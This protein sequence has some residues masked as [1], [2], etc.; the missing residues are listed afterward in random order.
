MLSAKLRVLLL[1]TTGL[2]T[3]LAAEAAS[4]QQ[5]G[6]GTT[7]SEV[8]V[9]TQRR[10]ERLLD[11]PISISAHTGEQLQRSGVNSVDQLS[12]VTPSVKIDSIGNYMQPAIRGVSSTVSGAGSDAPV[13]LYVDGVV[14]PNQ[15]V[16]FFEFADIDRIEVAKGPQ[17]TLFGR[18]ATGGAIAIFT[19]APSFTPTGDMSVSYG[20]YAH[21]I[22][23]VFLSG[24]LIRDVLAGSISGY[25]ER[26]DG[27]DFDVATQQRTKGLSNK[28][29][30]GK[31]LFQPTD[32]AK[33]T[34]IGSYTYRY[35]SEAGGGIALDG[36]SQARVLPFVV[37]LTPDPTAIIS[38]EPHTRSLDFPS[39]MWYQQK[40]ATILGQFNVGDYGTL[41]TISAYA[42]N[43][44][45]I[46]YDADR[47]ITGP[48]GL[49]SGV[50]YPAP[51]VFW[52]QEISFSSRKFGPV[53]FVSGLYA[54]YDN[55]RYAYLRATTL[56][57][58]A[59]DF[60]FAAAN[61]NHAYAVFTE[62]N[63]DLT[64]R[65]TLILGGRYSWERKANK[66][67]AAFGPNAPDGFSIPGPV[68]KFEA[69]TPRVSLKYKVT[70]Q[71][72]VYFTFSKGFKSGGIQTTA[73]LSPPAFQY[74][75]TFAPEKIA[76][77]EI[78]IK[79][80]PTPDLTLDAAAYYYKY[81]NLQV[82]VQ[83]TISSGLILNAASARIYGFDADA[84]WRPTPEIT[85]TGGMS[86]LDAKYSSFEDA[87]VFVPNFVPGIGLVGNNQIVWNATGNWMTRAPHYSFTA[88]ADYRR[89]F[90]PGTL[91]ANLTFAYT[92]TVYY[93]SIQRV[94][95]G[96]F[97]LLN[98]LA[99]WQPR[100]SNFR[101]D[102]WGKNL[103]NKTYIG[104]T[105]I[106]TTA[107]AVNYAPPRTYGV[108]INYN[109]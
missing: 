89:P 14:Q 69:F 96:P 85:L 92:G 55:N 101:F 97:G 36:S 100:G 37:P 49:N 80:R 75:S 74:L 11:V 108:T 105:L 87:S 8:I 45:H 86:W 94:H 30:R 2:S 58:P 66:G 1:A 23:K 50:S 20:N 106:E 71:T 70:D 67:S 88:V 33:I 3:F 91:D 59:A 26:H 4:A 65:L 15:N 47:A 79:S 57:S 25:Y 34:F 77:Y 90:T 9:T 93:D 6:G 24:P 60:S 103:T 38:A 31:L 46:S 83:T 64:D 16:N 22:S 29:V 78:G 5:A 81:T 82:Q 56:H 76:A 53:S 13:A 102:L 28:S 17:G 10:A 95:Q 18:N 61:P 62:I 68:L 72:N 52:S 41:N 98:G 84:T 27:Y 54:F 104:G 40:T 12:V 63:T 32:W 99:S 109:F 48:F 19:K 107:D 73:F 43:D 39:Y 44:V 35:N 21:V 51:D 42:H 7:V